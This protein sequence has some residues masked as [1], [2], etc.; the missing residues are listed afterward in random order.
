MPFT[1]QPDLLGASAGPQ[2][3][4]LTPASYTHTERLTVMSTS[5]ASVLK[6]GS[7]H[8]NYIT[9]QQPTTRESVFL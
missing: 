2:T 8:A 4:T 9:S 1:S 7:H 5:Y 6:E 3:F